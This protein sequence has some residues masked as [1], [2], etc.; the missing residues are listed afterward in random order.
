[1]EGYK[2][3]PIGIVHVNVEDKLVRFSDNLEGV[4]EIFEEFSEAL[5]NIEGFSHL[6]LITFLNKIDLDGRRILKVRLR[7]AL[8]KGVPEELVPEVG[9]FA[10]DS[11]HRPN[12]IGVSVVEVIKFE[13][14]FIYVKGIDV[15]DGTPVIDIKPYTSYRRVEKL[16]VPKWFSNIV[17]YIGREP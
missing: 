2:V 10:C 3:F 13:G 9:V 8:E 17:K 14:R 12:P 6:I 4:I 11:P 5:Y 7:R 1:M 15:F 16:Y